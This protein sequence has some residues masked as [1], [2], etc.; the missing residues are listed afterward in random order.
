ML[1]TSEK[2]CALPLQGPFPVTMLAGACRSSP[3]MTRATAADGLESCD[4]LHGAPPPPRRCV[5]ADGP[6][7][8]KETTKLAR[9]RDLVQNVG[10]DGESTQFC[11]I[12]AP[13]LAVLLRVCCTELTIR[14]FAFHK[15]AHFP[16]SCSCRKLGKVEHGCRAVLIAG[17]VALACSHS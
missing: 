8:S 13:G 15:F 7:A 9:L 1:C 2:A 3:A 5:A 6:P 12:F 11:C 17:D 4:E 16:Q 10:Q 14:R